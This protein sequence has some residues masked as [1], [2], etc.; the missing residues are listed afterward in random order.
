MLAVISIGFVIVST[1]ALILSTIPAFQVN[2]WHKTF[3]DFPH[4]ISTLCRSGF[5]VFLC[6]F[7]GTV[8]F[9]MCHSF[10]LTSNDKISVKK[11]LWCFS[12]ANIKITIKLYIEMSKKK[13]K[14]KNKSLTLLLY[15]TNPETLKIALKNFRFCDIFK[16]TGYFMTSCKMHMIPTYPT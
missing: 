14:K 8:L 2:L 13:G 7:Y 4:L 3:Y 5:I 12:R 11:L 10:K 1:A 15:G 16:K 6:K 9:T